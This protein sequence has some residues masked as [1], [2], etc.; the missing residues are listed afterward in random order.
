MPGT[1][2]FLHSQDNLTLDKECR[3]GKDDIES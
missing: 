2:N 1:K 3:E